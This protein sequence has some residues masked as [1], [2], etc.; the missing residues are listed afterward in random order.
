MVAL[1]YASP[2]RYPGGKGGLSRLLGHIIAL[3]G[4]ND[5][6]YAEPYAGGAGAALGLLYSERVSRVLINDIDP[7]VAAFWRSV[8]KQSTA[9]LR[10]VGQVSLTIDEWR[11]QREIYLHYHRHSSLRVGF[12]TFFLNRCNRSGILV[13]GGPI[14]G[15]DQRGIWKLDARFNREELCERISTIA[16][17]R[18]RILVTELDALVFLRT[19]VRPITATESVFVYLDPPYFEK[20]SLLY[21]DAYDKRAH[22]AVARFLRR[23]R[24]FRWVLSYDNAPEVRRIYSAFRQIPFDLAHTAYQRRCGRELLICRHDLKVPR[25]VS[26]WIYRRRVG[27][28]FGSS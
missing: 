21:H 25:D 14:G 4:F 1:S 19:V 16:A 18:D 26:A 20:G 11:R 6:V 3:N 27:A 23:Q 9:F 7:R 24:S 15:Y 2:L 10:L 5:A 17:Y 13:S 8:T 28:S 12:A 22:Q